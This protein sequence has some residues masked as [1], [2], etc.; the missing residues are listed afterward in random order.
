[1]K[2]RFFSLIIKHYSYFRWGESVF[3]EKI[4]VIDFTQV[5]QEEVGKNHKSIADNMRKK[6]YYQHLDTLNVSEIFLEFLNNF[7][8]RLKT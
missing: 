8:F 4:K 2:E 5:N 7:Y 1:M 3:R 6:P